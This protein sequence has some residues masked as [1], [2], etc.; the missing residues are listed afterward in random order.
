[1]ADPIA[2]TDEQR[3]LI[4]SFA[5]PIADQADDTLLTLIALST[6]KALA[7]VIEVS[8]EALAAHFADVTD[9]DALLK[10]IGS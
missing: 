2:L 7:P 5:G 1:M 4:R 8:I 9:T 3:D 10:A 6:M